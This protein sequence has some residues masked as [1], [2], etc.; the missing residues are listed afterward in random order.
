MK[1]NNFINNLKETILYLKS[2]DYKIAFTRYG[3]CKT[4]YSCDINKNKNINAISIVMNTLDKKEIQIFKPGTKKWELLDEI[5][6]IQQ[7]N[8]YPIFDTEL[9]NPFV[10]PRFKSYIKKNKIKNIV[11]IGGWAEHCILS[12]VNSCIHNNIVPIVIK[13]NIFGEDKNKEKNAFKIMYELSFI[14]PKES[15]K[16]IFL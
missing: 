10:I 12:N 15:I 6:S 7:E 1:R 3:R 14:I 8:N 5:K 11:L 13:D 2:K 4:E 9:L 16:Y